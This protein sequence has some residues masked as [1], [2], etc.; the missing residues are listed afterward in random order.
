MNPIEA[1]ME[2]ATPLQRKLLEGCKW[3]PETGCW[4]WVGNKGTELYAQ[5]K[6]KNV[7]VWS[8]SEFIGPVLDGDG[9]KSSC[10]N[11][12]CICPTHLVAK[13]LYP[14]GYWTKE[15][16]LAHSFKC[17]TLKEFNKKYPAAYVIVYRNGWSDVFSHFQSPHREKGYWTKERVFKTAKSCSSLTEFKTNYGRAY[18]L[19]LKNKW[20]DELRSIVPYDIVKRDSWTKRSCA[21]E[22]TKYSGRKEFERG[23]PRAYYA[24][25][26][27]GW[28]DEFF[29]KPA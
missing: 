4:E 27:N 10:N 11:Q 21:D 29:P 28:L 2:T 8:F 26:K 9:V 13:K 17:K 25:R 3:V 19:C 15:N 24:A 16:C 1:L 22:A 23:T 7:K 20:V 12:R 5:N 14:D 18:N 6:R